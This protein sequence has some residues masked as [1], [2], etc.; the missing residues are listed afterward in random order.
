MPR[1][2]AQNWCAVL[3]KELESGHEDRSKG[4]SGDVLVGGWRGGRGSSCRGG[5][6]SR[7]SR[8]TCG[9]ACSSRAHGG[10][11]GGTCAGLAGGDQ[12]GSRIL[13]T[14]NLGRHASLLG[15]SIIGVRRDALGVGFLAD[16]EGQGLGVCSAVGNGAI[17]ANTLVGEGTLKGVSAAIIRMYRAGRML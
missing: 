16:E 6:G 7:A 2:K 4:T 8:C 1:I 11:H 17:S 15:S 13:G 10:G 3:H 14:A 12:S 5:V 9:R